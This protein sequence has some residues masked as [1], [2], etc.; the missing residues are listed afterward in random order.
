M[1]KIR[2]KVTGQL[3]DDKAPTVLGVVDS[4]EEAD[5]I[6]ADYLNVW[7]EM[8]IKTEYGYFKKLIS[9]AK[10]AALANLFNVLTSPMNRLAGQIQTMGSK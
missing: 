7:P 5:A 8:V 4:G 1:A 9:R 10:A 6:A 3:I 2:I